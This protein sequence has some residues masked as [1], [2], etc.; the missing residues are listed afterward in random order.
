M[1]SSGVVGVLVLLLFRSGDAIGLI[2]VIL[3][4]GNPGLNAP[5][6]EDD[7]VLLPQLEGKLPPVHWASSNPRTVN[8]RVKRSAFDA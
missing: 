3:G 8:N 5:L 4:K 7:D 2:G 6:A 1:G